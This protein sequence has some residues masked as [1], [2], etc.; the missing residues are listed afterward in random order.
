MREENKREIGLKGCGSGIV[1][2]RFERSVLLVAREQW[3]G[4]VGGEMGFVGVT[5]GLPW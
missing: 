5:V 4:D 3:I 1:E 2:G